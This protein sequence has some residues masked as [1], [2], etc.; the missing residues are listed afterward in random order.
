MRIKSWHITALHTIEP[1]LLSKLIQVA[2]GI[3][4]DATLHTVTLG[5]GRRM[6]LILSKSPCFVLHARP[7]RGVDLI[8]LT[9]GIRQTVH[10]QREQV[11]GRKPQAAAAWATKSVATSCSETQREA[12]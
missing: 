12:L 11:H 10:L 9:T 6:A 3:T 7:D 5:L 4:L 8:L 2:I 1:Y